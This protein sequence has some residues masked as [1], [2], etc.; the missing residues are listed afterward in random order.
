MKI[1]REI[2]RL[3]K[4]IDL[5]ISRLFFTKVVRDVMYDIFFND[6]Y[7]IQS[8]IL[9]ALQKATKSMITTKFQSKFCVIS[10]ICALIEEQ[11]F[12]FCVIHAKRVILQIKNMRLMKTLREIMTKNENS[13]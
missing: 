12:N 2:K 8:K 10:F 9:K 4:S 11:M 13:H 3:Q 5:I 1:L 6:T 7:Q